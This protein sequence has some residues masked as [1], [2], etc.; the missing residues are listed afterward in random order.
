MSLL[1]IPYSKVYNIYSFVRIDFQSRTTL[2][3]VT[4][5]MYISMEIFFFR[6]LDL[7]TELYFHPISEWKFPS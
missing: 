6:T 4:E 3:E 2:F 7:M 5:L 1:G